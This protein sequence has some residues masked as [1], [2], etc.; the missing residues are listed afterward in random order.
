MNS[1]QIQLASPSD[2]RAARED[3]ISK[4]YPKPSKDKQIAFAMVTA[5]LNN[6]TH[7]ISFAIGKNVK[8]M[9]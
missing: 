3:W 1:S 4:A 2:L 5:A 8:G 9:K 7:P 6:E